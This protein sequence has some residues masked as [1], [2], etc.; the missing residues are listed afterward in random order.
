[1]NGAVDLPAAAAWFSP[2]LR[3]RPT[4]TEPPKPPATAERDPKPPDPEPRK[5]RTMTGNSTTVYVALALI[6]LAPAAWWYLSRHPAPRAVELT[7][8][9]N[10]TVT[11]F[12][13]STG[14][15]AG[16]R[17]APHSEQNLAP[18]AFCEPH[19][20]H[21][22]AEAYAVVA[23]YGCPATSRA[24]VAE[25]GAQSRDA[26]KAASLSSHSR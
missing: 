3:A 24:V 23:L 7:R 10:T 9:Q 15:A 25:A 11:I 12:R 2:D 17:R 22:T 21:F 20:G 8:S 1:M 4:P 5:V 19:D 14:R 26:G 18:A 13:S 16:A 6:T